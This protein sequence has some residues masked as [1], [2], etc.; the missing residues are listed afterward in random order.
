M[1]DSF[2]KILRRDKAPRL[3]KME[4]STPAVLKRILKRAREL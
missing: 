4:M 1:M 2:R 3:M